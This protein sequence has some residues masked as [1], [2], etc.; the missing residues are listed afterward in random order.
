MWRPV[1]ARVGGCVGCMLRDDTMRYESVPRNRWHN[2]D[3]TN[4]ETII[5]RGFAAF[6]SRGGRTVVTQPATQPSPPAGP[7]EGITAPSWSWKTSN[8]LAAATV[9]LAA[10]TLLLAIIS[11][12]VCSAWVLYKDRRDFE[13][14]MGQERTKQ[15][16]AARDQERARASGATADWQRQEAERQREE[17]RATSRLDLEREITDRAQRHEDFAITQQRLEQAS[18]LALQKENAK[19]QE[20]RV[21][22]I[23]L[24]TRLAEAQTQ[25]QLSRERDQAEERVQRE[26]DRER[27]RNSEMASAVSKAI[28][29]SFSD[30]NSSEGALAILANYA[31]LKEHRTAILE[32]I[33]AKVQGVRTAGEAHVII[34][35][36]R[37]ATPDSLNVACSAAVSAQSQLEKAVFWRFVTDY[38]KTDPQL[39][40]FQFLNSF[41]KNSTESYSRLRQ[42]F[43]SSISSDLN[44]R[45][46]AYIDRKWLDGLSV[47]R[48]VPFSIYALRPAVSV[49]SMVVR[50]PGLQ[51]AVLGPRLHVS[52]PRLAAALKQFMESNPG[53]LDDRR[54]DA[55]L[56]LLRESANLVTPN[57]NS[58]RDIENCNARQTLSANTGSR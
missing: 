32:V 28:S 38:L 35:I 51:R 40:P 20:A 36:L 8:G 54:L 49:A 56:Y 21:L 5:T 31:V 4:A 19:D 15:A 52:R 26:R 9:L 24:S 1:P 11:A 57:S 7:L 6:R 44:E 13:L 17:A 45:L 23:T 39:D 53:A 30:S 27:Q 55:Q 29:D 37:R 43:A 16:E 2:P 22:E 18:Q 33:S 10:A 47:V 48:F 14:S 42:D 34:D 41:L 12:I 25:A 58:F 3:G 50:V 46:R